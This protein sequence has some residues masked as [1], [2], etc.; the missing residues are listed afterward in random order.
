VETEAA[1]MRSPREI[2]I[3]KLIDEGANVLEKTLGYVTLT[4]KGIQEK[5]LTRCL[6]N[7]ECLLQAITLLPHR[8][9]NSE[10]Y[11]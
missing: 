10:L 6:Q 3:C 4:Q 9:N 2:A 11:D 8:K 5:L 1:E 7:E